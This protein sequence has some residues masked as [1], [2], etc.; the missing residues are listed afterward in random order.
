MRAPQ[1]DDVEAKLEYA[2]G[3]FRVISPGGYVKCAV[4]GKRIPLSELRYWSVDR[5]D[6][7]IDAA[8][9]SRA[10]GLNPKAD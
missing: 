4:T 5:Q 1:S 3:N 9:A 10:L 6:A 8:A 7:Y 2:D